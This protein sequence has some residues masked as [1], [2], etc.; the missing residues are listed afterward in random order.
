M[1]LFD[2][3][4]VTCQ[5]GRTALERCPHCEL[6]AEPRTAQNEA[7]APY[8][9]GSQTSFEAS[10]AIKP[11]AGKL[12]ERVFEAIRDHGP[13][14]DEAIAQVTRL[15]PSTAR[16]RRVELE[17]AGRIQKEGRQITS[18][19]RKSWAWVVTSSSDQGF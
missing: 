19:G 18:S 5:H 7:Q 10:Q 3:D 15:N 13:I 6:A 16:P 2:V 17:S 1:T 11:D 8:V 14:C 9:A 4:G 12:R